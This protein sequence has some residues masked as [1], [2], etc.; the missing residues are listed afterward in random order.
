MGKF[1]LFSKT[2]EK[3][4]MDCH[5]ISTLYETVGDKLNF[6]IYIV[7]W[8]EHS[9]VKW[10]SKDVNIFW[11]ATIHKEFSIDD[12][13]RW[14]LVP[15][16]AE[17]GLKNGGYGKSLDAKEQ[18]GLVLYY[19]ANEV[20]PREE[21]L[22]LVAKLYPMLGLKSY[23]SPDSWANTEKNRN[24][25]FGENDLYNKKALGEIYSYGADRNDAKVIYY[26]KDCRNFPEFSGITGKFGSYM[27]MSSLAKAYEN[28][29]KYNDAISTYE[30]MIID[31]PKDKKVLSKKINE[32]RQKLIK[33][34]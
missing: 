9:S 26:Y 25:I 23:M 16:H 17:H 18:I 2:L 11:E 24:I 31:D 1:N 27:C 3:R 33:T 12:Y 21:F 6:P 4:A 10:E 14:R 7:H 15:W 34:N 13:K 29:G 28:L 22:K 32:L 20:S 30:Q 5:V 8:P 19:A